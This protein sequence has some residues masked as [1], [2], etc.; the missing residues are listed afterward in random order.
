MHQHQHTAFLIT[1]TAFWGCDQ[2]GSAATSTG[3]G[4]GLKTWLST[5]LE[6]DVS[7]TC[8]LQ[9]DIFI[10]SQGAIKWVVSMYQ[11]SW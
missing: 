3:A 9:L 4:A 11:V 5:E 8:L 1:K 7:L 6:Q 10:A 2:L